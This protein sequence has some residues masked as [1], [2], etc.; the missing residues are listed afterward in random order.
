MNKNLSFSEKFLNAKNLNI[1]KNY[2]TYTF[3]MGNINQQPANSIK[4]YNNFY[5]TEDSDRY[6]VDN[7]INR[8]AFYNNNFL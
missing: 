3:Y 2:F 1:L 6:I 4:I 8:K 5:Y 7:K